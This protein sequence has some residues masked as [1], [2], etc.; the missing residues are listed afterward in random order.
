MA[1]SHHTLKWLSPD[2]PTILRSPWFLLQICEPGLEVASIT[3]AHVLL[4]KTQSHSPT[5][6]RGLESVV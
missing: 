3:S 1:Q 6:R 4:A 5:N 2:V